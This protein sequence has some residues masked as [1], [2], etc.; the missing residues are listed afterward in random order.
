[1]KRNRRIPALDPYRKPAPSGGPF[2]ALNWPQQR[3]AEQL[4]WEWCQKWGTNLPPWRLAILVARARRA[5]RARVVQAGR[6]R[7]DRQRDGRA[8]Q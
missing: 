4:L 5:G 2:A 3:T 8:A 6:D 7:P 1:M